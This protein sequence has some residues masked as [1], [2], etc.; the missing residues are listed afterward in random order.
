MVL[1]KIPI[2]LYAGGLSDYHEQN[3][4][5]GILLPQINT[6]ARPDVFQTYKT[7]QR[8]LSQP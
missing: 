4:Y 6:K 3:A 8:I 2:D 7:R 1:R 5:G